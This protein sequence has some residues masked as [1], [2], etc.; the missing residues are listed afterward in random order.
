M[1]SDRG[2]EEERYRGI[3]YSGVYDIKT[4]NGQKN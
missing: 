2:E 4:E 1:Y 3:K